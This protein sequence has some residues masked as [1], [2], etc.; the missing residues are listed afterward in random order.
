MPPS[1]LDAFARLDR[2]RAALRVA[3]DSVPHHLR[4]HPP[5]PDRWSVAGILEHIALVDE[6]FTSIIADKIAQAR[7]SDLGQEQESPE[8]LPPHVEG[9]LANRTER[10]QA[11][12]P[13]QP[14][15][16]TWRAAWD[17]AEEA[18][19]A[20]RRLLAGAEDLALSRVIYEHPRF[21]ALSAYQWAGFL[22]AH[23]SRHSAQVGEI[24][25]QM[26]AAE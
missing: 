14:T 1:L 3:V 10:R 8:P 11:P 22:S 5:G 21:G 25:A 2:S 6:R 24:A 20:F 7:T 13:V 26:V 15:G 16:L 4:D 12:A 23:E 19:A 17:R 9:M 18:R